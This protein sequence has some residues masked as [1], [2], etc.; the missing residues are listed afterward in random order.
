M[1]LPHF[2]LPLR[3]SGIIHTTQLAY[4]QADR[5]Y[6]ILYFEDGSREVYSKTLKLFEASLPAEHFV[7]ISK[8]YLVRRDYID[9]YITKKEI[10][11]KNGVPLKVARRRRL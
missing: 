10:K 9:G 5:N 2:R 3:Q 11:L 7:R 8:S 4:L 6:T 1:A